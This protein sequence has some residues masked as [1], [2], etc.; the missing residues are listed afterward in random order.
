MH[1]IEREKIA[2][3]WELHLEALDGLCRIFSMSVT[4]RAHQHSHSDLIAFES[5]D[6]S[7]QNELDKTE[8]DLSCL[9]T[10]L[11]WEKIAGRW[12][13]HLEALVRKDTNSTRLSQN[14]Q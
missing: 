6:L 1:Y 2:G 10:I 14:Q 3:R 5:L 11:R 13:P 12:E 9:C 7:S 8:R 4:H